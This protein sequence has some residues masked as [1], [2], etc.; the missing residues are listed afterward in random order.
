MIFGRDAIGVFDSGVGGLSV[1]RHIKSAYPDE[2]L[3]YFADQANVPYGS[4]S[5][6]DI[7]R[8]SAAICQFLLEHGAR[9]IVVACNTASAAA[10]TY[11]RDTFPAVPIV[12]MEPAVKPAALMTKTGKVGVL[13][14]PATFASPRY[15]ALMTRFAENV[16]VYE[17]PCVGL[18][19]LIEHGRLDAPETSHLLNDV[20]QPMLDARVDTLVLGCTHYPFVRPL[21]EEIAAA[22]S[23]DRS[24][25]IIDP[26]PAVARQVGRVLSQ[27]GLLTNGRRSGSVHLFT[28]QD[29]GTLS[30]LAELALGEKLPVT[31]VRWRGD[32][33]ETAG[34]D[35][36]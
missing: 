18:V 21:I 34:L 31:E 4:Q 24:V 33:L 15:S 17:D 2:N 36:L 16:T 1:L 25:A 8:F 35:S 13:A 20:L 26:A 5:V 23:D 11:L 10:L 22:H 7:R 29:T 6:E 14:T 3:L 30:V 19:N 32:I 27:A 28:S 12:G 9:I